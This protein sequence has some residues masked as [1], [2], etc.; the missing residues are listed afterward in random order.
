M[1]LLNL[2]LFGERQRSLIATTGF[3]LLVQFVVKIKNII[4]FDNKRLIQ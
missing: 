2:F 3:V 4:V 1:V